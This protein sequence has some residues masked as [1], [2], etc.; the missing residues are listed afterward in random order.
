M[1]IR[2]MSAILVSGLALAGV[3]ASFCR[4][5]AG[6]IIVPTA[7][8]VPEKGDIQV[9]P[10]I[11]TAPA[12]PPVPACGG[13]KAC[14][15][16]GSGLGEFRV[17]APVVPTT[18]VNSR[19]VHLNFEISDVG[20]SGVSSVELWATRDGKSWQRYSNEPPPSGPLVVHVAEEGRYGFS[21]IVRNGLGLAA[22]APKHGEA[23]QMWVD[24]DETKPVVK[25]TDCQVGKGPDAG[26]L[27]VKWEASD[28][29]LAAKPITICTGNTKD[30][31]WT[32]VATALEAAGDHTWQMPKDMPYEFYVRVE[33]TDRAG[34]VGYVVTHETMKVD[35][36]RPRGTI[37]GVGA[38]KK[39]VA[40]VAPEGVDLGFG[41]GV[42]VPP[43]G[44]DRKAVTGE[45]KQVFNFYTGWTR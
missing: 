40:K 2:L 3:L 16:V 34:N 39:P 24:V 38:E 10:E 36:A 32:P 13:P 17:E 30:G 14:G 8:Q 19:R 5:P 21:I 44:N 22:A 15:L 31:P 7:A 27:H 11:S 42:R 37:L 41:V 6:E 9:L 28:V 4:V 18:L 33:A 25:M 43:L 35:L 23:P 26:A 29:N 12:T 1:R 45:E 20:P